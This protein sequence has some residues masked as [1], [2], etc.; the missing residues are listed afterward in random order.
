MRR[1][2]PTSPSRPARQRVG[3]AAAPGDNDGDWQEF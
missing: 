1:P 2:A 3:N